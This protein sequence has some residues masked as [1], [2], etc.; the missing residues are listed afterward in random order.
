MIAAISL[1][2]SDPL[3]F[4]FSEEQLDEIFVQNGPCT[5]KCVMEFRR[6]LDRLEIYQFSQHLNQFISIFRHHQERLTVKSLIQLFPPQFSEEGS[7]KLK[8]EKIVYNKFIKYVREAAAGRRIATLKD[9]LIFVTCADGIPILGFAKQPFIPF[10]EVSIPEIKR[11]EKAQDDQ[12][13][14]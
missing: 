13:S 6:G 8:F 10:H 7:N 1:L 2:Q 4:Y 11:K 14:V 5:S 9:I 3:P 12:V